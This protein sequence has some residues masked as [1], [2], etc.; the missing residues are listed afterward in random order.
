MID[1]TDA[2]RNAIALHARDRDTCVVAGPGSG[3]TTVLIERF[4]GLVES[5]VRPLS[6]LAITFTEKATNQIRDRLA[7]AF[8]GDAERSAQIRRAYVSTVHGFCTR[9]L[10][11]HAI[12]AGVDPRF[13][14]LNEQEAYA[15][16]ERSAVDALDRF[17][18]E[19][20]EPVRDLLRSLYTPDLEN[21]IINIYDAM[22]AAGMGVEDLAG[23]SPQGGGRASLDALALSATPLMQADIRLWTPNQREQVDST[24]EWAGR[25]A[26]RSGL[27]I[28][29]ADFELVAFRC[30]LGKVPRN[31]ETTNLLKRLREMTEAAEPLVSADFYAAQ[32]AT[33]IE[34]IGRFDALYRK[35]KVAES[36]LD[37][38]DLE[39]FTV[40]LLEENEEARE[41]IRGQFEY[42][43]MD[44]F[45]DTNGLQ[46]KLLD[47]LRSPD[48]FYAVG[49]INQSIYGFRHADPQVFRSYRERVVA[50]GRHLAELRE[51]W[52]SR[53]EILDAVTSLVGGGEGVEPHSFH[54]VR[55]FP[56]KQ[57]PS[58][59]VIRCLGDE[60]L[61]AKWVA[62]R[63]VAMRRTLALESRTAEFGDMAVLVRKADNIA[64]LTAAF[65]EA[66]IP[67]VV[68]AGKGFYETRE[69]SDLTHL[70]R[71]LAN[72]R[73]EISLAAVLRS[74]LVGA[75]DATLLRMKQA[76]GLAAEL[77]ET[78]ADAVREFYRELES[79]RAARHHVSAD[80][81]LIRAMDRSGYELGLRAREQANVEKFLHMVREASTRKSLDELVEELERLRESDPRE[82]DSQAEDA[83]DAV[84]IM[85]V[86]SAKGLEFPIVFLPAFQTAMYKG[87][88]PVAFSPRFGM[89]VRWRNPATG[90]SAPDSLY[91][92]IT[93]EAKRKEAAESNRLLYVAMTRAKEHLVLSCSGA[94]KLANWA[95]YLES[96]WRLN[97]EA[98]WDGP[99]EERITGADG[100]SFTAR[101]VCTDRPPEASAQLE[102]ALDPEGPERITPPK[103]S[104]QQDS[105]ASVTSIA[106]FADCPRRYYLARYLGWDV[107]RSSHA[108]GFD[109]DEVERDDMDPTDFGRH[110]HALLAGAS[111]DGAHPEAVALASRFGASDLGLRLG[112]AGRVEREFDFLLVIEDLVL[113][114]QIDLWFEESGRAVIVDYKTDNVNSLEAASRSRY[115]E[116]QL[117]LYALAVERITGERP[118]RAS[119]YFLRPDVEVLV[120]LDAAKLARAVEI[121]REFRQ[122]QDRMEFPLREGEHCVRCPYFRGMCPAPTEK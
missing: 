13:R 79:W 29:A 69:V 88:G 72:P 37:F 43:L 114:G 70:L 14:V 90:K 102:L 42:I 45:Q 50:D 59:E 112:R 33:L 118:E 101:A 16:E 12:L 96:S 103:L 107:E 105:T 68:T 55:K 65:D 54:A 22:R 48:R 2:Q 76:G 56:R 10:R 67:Y 115:Y 1:F 19:D 57:E 80:R 91:K 95:K 62:S 17:L 108:V 87:L 74:P 27:A 51:N 5:G 119:L 18:A 25:I 61:E 120:D 36:A 78:A 15:L 6:I 28:A 85:T 52:R 111:K 21:S 94:G 40:R 8:E 44:E 100:A 73:D 9:L 86:H 104:G 64:P 109:G 122:A 53:K 75:S 47:L 71:V 31:N 24:K 113:R 121:V 3:K 49:D 41:S 89:G 98:P 83:G 32:R 46:S 23:F 81:L 66:S 99:R 92:D 30:N 7:K 116:L 77:P 39:E 97:L 58:I 110:V 4:R 63:I 34:A 84:R 106:L 20:P 117:Q 60:A 82:Q 11:E 26:E 35:R 93:D 38:S